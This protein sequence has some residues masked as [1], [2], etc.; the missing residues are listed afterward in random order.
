ME[1]PRL[2]VAAPG[3]D[4]RHGGEQARRQPGLA[5]HGGHG[6]AAELPRLGAARRSGGG[7]VRPSRGGRRE[8]E[9]QDEAG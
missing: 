9:E 7:Y 8:Q 5:L 6:G 1:P 4:A 3:F 2:R